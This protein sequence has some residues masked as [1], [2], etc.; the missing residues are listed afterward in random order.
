MKSKRE[1]SIELTEQAVKKLKSTFSTYT[2]EKKKELLANPEEH[3]ITEIGKNVLRYLID[4]EEKDER[5]TT[6]LQNPE[7]FNILTSEVN[8]K[9]V[10]E[11]STIKTIFLCANGRLVENAKKTSYNLMINDDAGSGKD[12]VTSKTLEIIPKEQ[13]CHRTRISEKVLT[14][15]HNPKFEPDWTWDG[16]VFYNEDISNSTLNSEVF[17]VF[18]SSGSK[19]TVLV[20]QRPVDIEIRGK[21][22]LIITCADTAP[23]KELLRRFTICDLDGSINQTKLIMKR[24]AAAAAT[25]EVLEYDEALIDAQRSLKRIKVKVLFAELLL[26]VFP[27]NH[28][29]MR[30]HFDRFLDYIKAACAIYQYQREQDD[31]GYFLATGQDYDIAR[32]AL[33]KTTSN[34]EMIPLTKDERKILKLFELVLDKNLGYSVSELV[35]HVNW[36]SERTLYTK[37]KKLA[38]YGFLTTDSEERINSKKPVQVFHY[39]DI[40]NISIPTWEE[41]NKNLANVSNDTNVSNVSNVSNDGTIERIETIASDF[42]VNNK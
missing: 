9:V 12:H 40:I 21:P 24:Q 5:A 39:A 27:S 13:W 34:K 20:E 4:K 38:D 41:L 25:G 8:K 17:K 36:I 30:T 14:Y 28:I 35:P 7:L 11:E 29:I 26:A 23:N 42:G 31:E 2:L 6:Y 32:I 15:W 37:L 19:A 18:A 3:N 33:Q 1:E 10:R 16:K 22:V